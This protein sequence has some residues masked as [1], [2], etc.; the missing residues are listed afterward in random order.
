MKMP[1]TV[2]SL[3]DYDHN[4]VI[5]VLVTDG[6]RTDIVKL[7]PTIIRSRGQARL[8]DTLNDDRDRLI[9][10]YNMPQCLYAS[11]I[12]RYQTSSIR[13]RDLRIKIENIKHWL[14][15]N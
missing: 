13:L 2:I 1:G 7:P 9:W 6:D 4:H 5:R 8:A 11:L 3:V 12:V 15:V 10:S 14:C